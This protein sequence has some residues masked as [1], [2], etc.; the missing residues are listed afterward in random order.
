MNP[1]QEREVLSNGEAVVTQSDG[2]VV[3]HGVG[4][5][6]SV[7]P[8]GEGGEP[9]TDVVRGWG[10]RVAVVRRP[11]EE[12]GTVGR[13]GPRSRPDMERP[14]PHHTAARGTIGQAHVNDANA[15]PWLGVRA[16]PKEPGNS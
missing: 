14:R 11:D 6:A 15:G 16:H 4:A 1:P 2:K 12:K 9:L 3:G 7:A 13:R 8:V 5:D 10:C